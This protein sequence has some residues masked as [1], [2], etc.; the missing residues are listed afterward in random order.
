MLGRDRARLRATTGNL[1][2]VAFTFAAIGRLVPRLVHAREGRG[3]SGCAGDV[4]IGSRAERVVVITAGLV[5]APWIG[6]QWVD[7]RPRRDRL[8]HRPPADLERPHAAS[9]QRPVG[10]SAIV[11]ALLCYHRTRKTRPRPDARRAQATARGRGSALRPEPERR[12]RR[13]PRLPLRGPVR[14]ERPA[15]EGAAA[16]AGAVLLRMPAELKDTLAARA[17]QRKRKLNE[18]IVETLDD[19][20]SERNQWQRRNGKV[21]RSDGQGPRRDHR[22][23]QLRQLAPAGRRVLQGRRPGRSSSRA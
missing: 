23:R 13:H 21:R 6:L 12:R 16:A 4:G 8:V 19:A 22:R 2:A 11:L 14:A 9:P 3:C 20:A 18:L 5:L 7:L 17:A 1:V 10:V 15:G